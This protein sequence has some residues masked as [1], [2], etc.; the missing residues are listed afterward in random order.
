MIRFLLWAYLA[1]AG[2]AH[3]AVGTIDYRLTDASGGIKA[4]ARI[5]PD[6]KM[7]RTTLEGERDVTTLAPAALA[8]LQRKLDDAQLSTLQPVYACTACPEHLTHTISV[9][10]DGAAYTVR[11][12]DM[13]D[14]PDRLAPLIDLLGQACHVAVPWD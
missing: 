7:T 10:I 9:Q 2:C 14:I 1:H 8:D 4:S 13:A 11:I 5:E 3:H 6:G 12:A